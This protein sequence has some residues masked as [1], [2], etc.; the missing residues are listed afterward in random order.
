[1]ANCSDTSDEAGKSAR[2]EVFSSARP[3]TV[4]V[5][6]ASG[7]L[8]ASLAEHLGSKGHTIAVHYRSDRSR[9]QAEEVVEKIVAAKGKAHAFQ[10][11]LAATGEADRLM[12]EVTDKLG[13][14]DTLVNNAGVYSE[15][16]FHDL[17][18]DDFWEGLGSTIG[19]AFFTTRAALPHLRSSGRGRVVSIGDSLC[20]QPGFSE[21][22]FSYYVG[23]TGIWMMTKTLA[24]L[25]APYG[26]TVNVISPGMLENSLGLQPLREM[27]AGRFATFEDIHAALD[28]FL[29][30][31]AGYMTGNNLLVAGGFNIA[32]LQKSILEQAGYKR[33]E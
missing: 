10:A 31:A 21:P 23:K 30:D 26:V 3:R 12:H 28:F 4:V 17:T 11:D 9:K 24:P 15:K 22:A 27:P 8:G 32:P 33:E 7:R 25:E 16:R 13:L 2:P 19:A 6:G 5:T 14:P 1:M 18:P 29:S 20:D